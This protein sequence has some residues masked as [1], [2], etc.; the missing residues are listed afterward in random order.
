MIK[1][2]YESL[3]KF[4]G[5]IKLYKYI[6]IL[7]INNFNNRKQCDYHPIN[8]PYILNNDIIDNYKII[9][10]ILN[11]LYSNPIH[12]N[13]QNHNNLTKSIGIDISS[14]NRSINMCFYKNTYHMDSIKKKYLENNPITLESIIELY[15]LK[16][17]RLYD[18]NNNKI[19][20]VVSIDSPSDIFKIL[21]ESCESSQ[22][23]EII[24]PAVSVIY[25]NYYSPNCQPHI[26][27]QT[28]FVVQLKNLCCQL[29]KCQIQN[30]TEIYITIKTKYDIN[31]YQLINNICSQL[32]KKNRKCKTYN[33]Y[34]N[35][36]LEDLV[37]EYSLD[38]PGCSIENKIKSWINDEIQYEER[39]DNTEVLILT[40][41][42]DCLWNGT[43]YTL[44]T[45]SHLDKGCLLYSTTLI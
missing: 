32:R 35:C 30:G 28:F 36:S 43:D 6:D 20:F 9:E 29:T 12:V 27:N 10:N 40:N 24:P 1:I 45:Q 5:S 7:L 34:L 13:S 4:S 25:E 22:S 19:V 17:E 21:L 18:V 14:Y 39:K 41:G 38:N 44:I 3:C 8:N 15:Q 16:S 37:K 23:I 33:E 42:L 26:L 31:K 11:Q 2:E